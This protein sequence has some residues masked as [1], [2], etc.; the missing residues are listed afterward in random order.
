MRLASLAIV[1]SLLSSCSSKHIDL[2]TEL[3]AATGTRLTGEY[4]VL[5]ASTNT[6]FGDYSLSADLEFTTIGYGR[7]LAA[8]PQQALKRTETGF[9]VVRHRSVNGA[10]RLTIASFADHSRTVALQGVEE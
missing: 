5:N 9:Q 10:D 8:I 4:K 7:A 2:D 1:V 3:E 6:A